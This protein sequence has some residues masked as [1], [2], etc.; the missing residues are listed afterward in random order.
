METRP[1]HLEVVPNA[2]ATKSRIPLPPSPRSWYM[3][4]RSCELAAGDVRALQYFGQDLVLYR[5]SDGSPRLLDAYC[6]HLGAHLGHGGCVEGDTIRC[7]FHGWKFD[8][9]G[10]CVAIPYAKKIP[11]TAKV[12]SWPIREKNGIVYAFYDPKGQKPAAEWEP[13]DVPQL[14]D[15]AWVP[16]HWCDHK[17]R[18]HVQ[19]IAENLADVAHIN[20]IHELEIGA[21]EAQP[22][23][24]NFK[25]TTPVKSDGARMGMPGF[26]IPFRFRSQLYGLGLSTVRLEEMM[27][28]SI[29]FTTATPID[30]E[31]VHLRIAIMTGKLPS[32]EATAMMHDLLVSEA[33]T[34]MEKEIQI[35]EH[36]TYLVRP[37]LG[38]IEGA[39]P[40]FRRW[41]KQFYEGLGED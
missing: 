39:L 35:W 2:S 34:N 10:Q 27:F 19:E 5:S 24:I 7:P 1:V 13:P 40:L 23:G 36:K 17:I 11:P 32:P 22:D 3:I 41:S 16:A 12:R 29:V 6:P 28:E 25:V 21:M 30:G 37:I 8:S 18:S 33:K 38:D 20:V 9:T 15:E 31:S 14:Q 26:E 4:A